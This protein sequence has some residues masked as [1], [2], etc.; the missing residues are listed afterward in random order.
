MYDD[1]KGFP[2]IFMVLLILFLYFQMLRNVRLRG[3]QKKF[4]KIHTVQVFGR[5][6]RTRTVTVQTALVLVRPNRQTTDSFFLKSGQNPD[7]GQ[8]R[9]RRNPDRQAPD[10]IF[11]KI[12]TKTRQGEDTDN[13]VRRR[14]FST[15]SFLIE[16]HV[17]CHGVEAPI[18]F[19]QS[20]LK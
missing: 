5:R 11:R 19:F 2:K 8:N 18:L 4:F 7:S 16:W 14:L 6:L 15:S 9:D 20:M 10:T 13:A 17:R 3:E 12:R 1:V